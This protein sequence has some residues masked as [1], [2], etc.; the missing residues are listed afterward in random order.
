M[1]ENM[2]EWMDGWIDKQVGGEGS[3]GRGTGGR[4]VHAKNKNSEAISSY[5]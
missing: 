2:S 3:V 5:M 1:V 4:I